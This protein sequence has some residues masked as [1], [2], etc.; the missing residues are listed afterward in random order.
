MAAVKSALEVP[1]HS[2]VESGSMSLHTSSP[3]GTFVGIYDGHGGGPNA[4]EFIKN[5]LFELSKVVLALRQIHV[6]LVVQVDICFMGIVQDG[7]LI[8]SYV[9]YSRD[10]GLTSDLGEMSSDVLDLSFFALDEKYT[11]LVQNES[12]ALP[13]LLS[14]GSSCLVGIVIGGRTTRSIGD[15]YLKSWEFSTRPELPKEYRVDKKFD[16][17]IISCKPALVDQEL[18]PKDRFIIFASPGLW[19]YVADEE[20]VDMVKNLSRK[21][22][23]LI[24]LL[25]V[26]ESANF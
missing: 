26:D 17:P 20:A 1:S 19:K 11:H 16:K 3:Y 4:S 7:K 22:R 25:I 6:T 23:F 10:A 24:L 14:A 8:P 18:L 9:C 15:V 21:V 12:E 5:H 2:Q 13:N